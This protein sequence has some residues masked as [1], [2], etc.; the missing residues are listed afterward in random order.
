M[1]QNFDISADNIIATNQKNQEAR[2]MS[3]KNIPVQVGKNPR[4][5]GQKKSENNIL[6]M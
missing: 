5:M 4:T 1:I 2:P 3:Q 6:M